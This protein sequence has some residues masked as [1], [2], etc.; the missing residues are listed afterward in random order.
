[1]KT[2]LNISEAYSLA[3]HAAAMVASHGKAGPVTAHRIATRLGVSEAH[4]SKVLQRLTKSGILTSSRGPGGGFSLGMPAAS[5]T[6]LDI[7]ESVEGPLKLGRCLIGTHICG[8]KSCVF[9][10]LIDKVNGQF[11]DYLQHT[12]VEMVKDTLGGDGGNDQKD[13]RDR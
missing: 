11:K 3:L 7:Y 5:I 9:D 4:L 6:L 2:V 12:T 13:N 1:M 10:D 8:G